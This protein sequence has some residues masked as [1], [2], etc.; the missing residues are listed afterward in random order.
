MKYLRFDIKSERRERLEGDKFAPSGIRLLKTVKE[1]LYLTVM[2]LDEQLLPCKA[3]CKFIQYISTKPDKFAIK[4]CFAADARKYVFDGFPYTDRDENRAADSSVA[5]D[6]ATKLLSPLFDKVTTWL[7][8]TILPRF[9]R[10]ESY[11]QKMHS[12]RDNAKKQAWTAKWNTA[13]GRFVCNFNFENWRWDNT[14][15]VSM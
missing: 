1:L 15:L 9:H 12:C 3:R 11:C 2:S 7:A 10:Q 14:D 8:T 5:T 13:E 4:F 6:T